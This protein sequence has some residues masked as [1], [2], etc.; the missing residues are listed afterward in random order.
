[1]PDDAWHARDGALTAQIHLAALRPDGS[2]DVPRGLHVVLE[3]GAN[4]RNTLDRELLPRRPD[5]FLVTFEPLLDKYAALLARNSRPDVRATLGA[6]HARGLVLPF[7]LSGDHNSIRQFKISGR[8]DGCA[9]LLNPVSSYYSQDCTNLTGVLER[10]NVPSVSL[11]VVL[12]DWLRGRDVAL[13]KVDAQG[14]DVGVI[15]SAGPEIRRLKAVQLEV[16]RDRP[17]GDGQRCDAQYAS[18][19]GRPQE[20][21]CNVVV[22][23]M[24]GL[25]FEPY[26]T[27]CQVH[28]FKE[29]GGCEA[30]MMFVRP[31]DFN[32]ELVRSFC[33][34]GRPHSCGPGAWS[35]KQDRRGWDAATK[36]WADEVAKGWPPEDVRGGRGGKR[37]G[38]RNR[39]GRRMK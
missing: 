33:T 4:S 21:K 8:T 3:V 19:P 16:V 29:A 35:L 14:L 17:R 39:D 9:S 11:Q 24:R 25:G 2:L 30:E 37:M 20:V 32:E 23:A 38:R 28:K 15:R 26:A 7:A 5:A 34:A 27:N 12:R 31:G 6:H 36:A 22:S 1:M 10:R 13:A 18:E